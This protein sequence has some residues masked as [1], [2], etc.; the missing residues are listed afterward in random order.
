MISLFRRKPAAPEVPVEPPLPDGATY[1][2][3]RRMWGHDYTINEVIDGG[4]ELHAAGWGPMLSLRSLRRGDYL[5]LQ[6]K[7]PGSS[8]RYQVTAVR[9]AFD[10]ND[11]WFATLRFAPRTA[12]GEG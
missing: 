11:M 5:I 12:A 6:G 9:Y 1:D 10:P 4:R 8:T 2:Y 7:A 3:T